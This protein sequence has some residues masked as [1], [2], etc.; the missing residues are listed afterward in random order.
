M[1]ATALQLLLLAAACALASAAVAGDNAHAPRPAIAAGRDRAVTPA[2]A[3]TDDVIDAD[4]PL[5]PGPALAEMPA[6]VAPTTAPLAATEIE[7]LGW[8]LAYANGT[9]T[10]G[11]AAVLGR[12][13]PRGHPTQEAQRQWP[14]EQVRGVHILSKMQ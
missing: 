10:G 3:A 11:E 12:D 8:T 1:M 2:R 4:A 7:D 6:L 13:R 9:A 14:E 5:R